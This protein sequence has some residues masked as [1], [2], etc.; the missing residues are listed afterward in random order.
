MQHL[1]SQTKRISGV[2]HSELFESFQQQ[3]KKKT[4]LKNRF[5]AIIESEQQAFFFF[6]S[7]EGLLKMRM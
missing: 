1:L 6:T 3:Q 7:F 4:N 2:G 5:T